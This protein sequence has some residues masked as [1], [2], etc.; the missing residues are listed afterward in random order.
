[1]VI[2]QSCNNRKLYDAKTPSFHAVSACI[3]LGHKYQM[4]AAYEQSLE[5][6]KRHYTSDFKVWDSG[7]D[8]APKG[9]DVAQVI[10]VVNLARFIEEP[11]ILPTALMACT[12]LEGRIFDGYMREDGTTEHLS[13]QDLA[14]CVRAKTNIQKANA[15]VV[16][17]TLSSPLSSRCTSPAM[18]RAQVQAAFHRL[19]LHADDL[20]AGSPFLSYLTCVK[21]ENL[22]VCSVCAKSLD[23]TNWAERQDMWNRLPEI[24]KIEVPGWVPPAEPTAA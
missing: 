17:R 19:H 2:V 20:V 4:T 18:C 16:L 9:W 15:A 5:F 6:L 7:N 22:G 13:R 3:R 8:W 21:D 1:M 23:K 14:L 24:L 10:G 11:L 12:Q